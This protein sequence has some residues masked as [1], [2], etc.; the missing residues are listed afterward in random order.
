MFKLAMV[1]APKEAMFEAVVREPLEKSLKLLHE[2]GFNGVELS[3]ID[4]GNIEEANIEA[5][6]ARAKNRIGHF[7]VADSNRLA[8]G[9]G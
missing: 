2:I 7:H 6:I 4:P 1:V 9:M 5:S 8:P 3:V